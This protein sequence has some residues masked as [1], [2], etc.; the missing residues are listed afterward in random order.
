MHLQQEASSASFASLE[1]FSHRYILEIIKEED[2]TQ[3]EI[4]SLIKQKLSRLVNR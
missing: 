2:A 3:K 1:K 4:D